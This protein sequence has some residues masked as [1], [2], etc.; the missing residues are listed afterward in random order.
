MMQSAESWRG[1]DS[2]TSIRVLRC[3]TISGRSL[4]QRKM[5]SVFVIIVNVFVH[6]PLQM[7]FIHDD[8]MIEQI[9]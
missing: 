7:P 3:N 4:R 1:Y 8:D 2:A 9:G 6:E 5:R